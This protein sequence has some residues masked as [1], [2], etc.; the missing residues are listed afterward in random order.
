MKLTMTRIEP[1]DAHGLN[2]AAEWL[3]LWTPFGFFVSIMRPN[4]TGGR[5]TRA[6]K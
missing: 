6:K 4:H 1:S 2:A 5:T 3:E